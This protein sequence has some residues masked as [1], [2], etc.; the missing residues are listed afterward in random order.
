MKLGLLHVLQHD[1][2]AALLCHNALVVGQVIGRGLNAMSAVAGRENFINHTNGRLAAELGIAI[3]GIDGQIV[4]HFLQMIAEELQ[5]G[6]LGVVAKIHISF[7]SGF[8]AENFIVVRFVGADGDVDG[9]IQIHP[10]QIAL[11]IIVGAERGGARQ[12]EFLAASRFRSC[13]PPLR[14]AARLSRDRP[15]IPGCREPFSDGRLASRRITVKK[16][17]ACLA[18]GRRKSLRPVFEFLARHVFGIKIR[19]RQFLRRHAGEERERSH[20]DRTKVLY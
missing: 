9:R 1:A 4:L 12:Q 14:A 7:E 20:P 15:C 2:L 13:R 16:P 3:L 10:R 8:V 19:A 18:L 5:L 17:S 6:G 11:V